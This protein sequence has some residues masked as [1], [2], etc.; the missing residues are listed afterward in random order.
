M[1]GRQRIGIDLDNT[2]INYDGVFCS[3]AV[4]HG[5][6]AAPATPTK[7]AVREAI[8]ALPDGELAWQRLQGVVYGKGVRDALLFDGAEAFLR[9][10]RRRGCEVFIVSHKTEFG[11]YD[12]DR[13]NL[14]QAALA[15]M[16]TQG[17]F[18]ANGFGIP[19]ANVL[20]A[21]TR[22]EKIA[23]IRELGVEVFIDDLPE[24]LEDSDFPAAVAGILFTGGAEAA[25]AYPRAAAHWRDITA[26]VFG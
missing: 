26:M 17:F 20:F 19:S 14:R 12:P 1:A 11:H 24:V 15:W 6:I 23:A 22:A 16:E 13:V 18:A 9:A 7:A 25:S 21:S 10:A 5:L 2:L 8:R 3:L 4:A